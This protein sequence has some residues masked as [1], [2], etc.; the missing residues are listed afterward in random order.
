MDPITMIGMAFGALGASGAFDGESTVNYPD[1]VD[2]S[3]AMAYA[4]DNNKTIALGQIMSQEFALQ[5]ASVDR[6]MQQAAD[7]ELGIEKLDTKLQ[8]AR[9]D[10]IQQMNQEDNKHVEKMTLLNAGHQKAASSTSGDFPL[11]EGVD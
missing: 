6:E 3:E 9:L 10:F 1:P 7:L 4:S 2:Y 5:Q 11:P 8:T